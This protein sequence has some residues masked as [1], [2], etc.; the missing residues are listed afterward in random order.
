MQNNKYIKDHIVSFLMEKKS[1]EITDPLLISWLEE[2]DSNRHIFNQYQ[3]IWEESMHYSEWENF[4]IE[5]SWRRV[6]R[7]NR[8]KESSRKRIRRIYFGIS[9]IAASLLIFIVL[10]FMGLF[11]TK[12]G[13]L[14]R[15]TTETGNRSEII[16]P[17]GSKVRLN[18][19]SEIGYSY[20]PRK[21]I[22][23]VVFTGE[24][25]FEVSKNDCP[26][27]VKL[28]DGL[29]V[30][31]LGTTFNL[32][33]YPED[34]IIQTSLV[35]GCIELSH[36]NSNILMK[37]GEMGIFNKETQELKQVEGI[38]IHAYGWL[39]DKLYMDNMSLAEV[40]RNLERRYD[41]HISIQG[42]LGD[43]IRYNGV[44]QE[45]TVT[46]VMDALSRLS[47]IQYEMKGQHISIT[48]K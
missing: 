44:I 7:I 35:E 41:I 28:A 12:Q 25:Y 1:G 9:G 39:E 13:A 42:T 18:S 15:M 26:F 30:K 36:N 47:N 46:D 5:K 10:S 20:N 23:E 33:A 31:V 40:C 14:V 24:G 6:D 29:N 32:K 43:S 21:K 22:R 45:K 17:D 11:E 38:L 34:Q 16:L 48:S 27:I 2:D 19:N 37:S 4:D 3:K 8:Q